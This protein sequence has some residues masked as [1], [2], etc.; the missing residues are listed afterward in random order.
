MVDDGP[1]TTF[2]IKRIYD[3]PGDDGL[4]VLVDRL[5]P[6]GVRKEDAR[7]DRWAK[8]ATPTSELRK[9]FHGGDLSADEFAERYRGELAE[10]GA[11]EDLAADLPDRVTLVTAVKDPEHSHVPVL[12]AELRELTG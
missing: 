8:Q 11:A 9:A 6:R 4:R 12:L 3:G 7:I 5:W 1:M 10:S 2:A